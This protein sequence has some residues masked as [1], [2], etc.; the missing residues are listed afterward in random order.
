M[1]ADPV[2]LHAMRERLWIVFL[3]SKLRAIRARHT[4][5]RTTRYLAA[6]EMKR[7]ERWR[8]RRRPVVVPIR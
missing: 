7:T 4:L 6:N 2:G 5:E 8:R 3:R 1:S